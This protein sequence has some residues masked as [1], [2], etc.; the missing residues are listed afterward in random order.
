MAEARDSRAEILI[1]TG[2]LV[3]LLFVWFRNRQAGAGNG[4][5]VDLTLPA[6][7]NGSTNAG[8]PL[9][10]TMPAGAGQTAL[11]QFGPGAG[12]NIGGTTYTLANPSTCGCG[13]GIGNTY[14]SEDDLAASLVA[15]NYNVPSVTNAQGFY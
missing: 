13:G 1:V 8:V 7:S 6:V 11:Q 15:A 12:I 9:A 4:L 3:L 14:G 2:V 10:L 5:T